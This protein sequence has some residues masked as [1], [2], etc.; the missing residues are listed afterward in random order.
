M[1]T[2]DAFSYADEDDSGRTG[3]LI[4]YVSLTQ[5]LS[6]NET[7]D[8]GC[9]VAVERPGFRR[10]SFLFARIKAVRQHR[11]L[12]VRTHTLGTLQIG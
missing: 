10:Q 7:H 3:V 12:R 1:R 8:D 11:T 9:F 5:R 2:E 6:H 4:D